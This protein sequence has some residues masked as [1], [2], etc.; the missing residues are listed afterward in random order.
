[1]YVPKNIIHTNIREVNTYNCMYDKICINEQ[2]KGV[3]NVKFPRLKDLREDAELRQKDVADI[4]RI[5]QQHYSQY[6]RGER[7]LPMSY[8]IILAKL[9]KVSL[10]YIAGLTNKKSKKW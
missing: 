7:E 4:L 8:F 9:Y 10:D 5:S 1:M 2:K 6:E 3:K